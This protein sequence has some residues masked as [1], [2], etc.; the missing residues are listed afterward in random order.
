MRP[1]AIRIEKEQVEEDEKD[2]LVSDP[3]SDATIDLWRST[4]KKNRDIFTY[5]FQPVPSDLVPNWEAYKV[6]N[7]VALSLLGTNEYHDGIELRSESEGWTC[8]AEY[9][10]EA[11][12]GAAFRS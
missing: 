1:A 11:G 6:R 4:A 12:E 10:T 5:V 3:L 8:C 7:A 2:V 9:T